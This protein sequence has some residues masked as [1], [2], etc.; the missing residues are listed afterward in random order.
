MVSDRLDY[1]ERRKDTYGRPLIDEIVMRNASVHIE[2]MNRGS[3]F[4]SLT[5]KDGNSH[6]IWIHATRS[7]GLQIVPEEVPAAIGLG[8]AE[9]APRGLT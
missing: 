2:M 1:D 5:D 7:G 9:T 3:A 8:I 4:V 6:R